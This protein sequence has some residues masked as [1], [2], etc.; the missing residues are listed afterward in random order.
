VGEASLAQGRIPSRAC[1]TQAIQPNQH[2]TA[3]YVAS[4][5]FAFPDPS[6]IPK[7][8]QDFQINTIAT[9][10]AR[11][12]NAAAIQFMF[13]SRIN[14]NDNLVEGTWMLPTAGLGTVLSHQ[15]ASETVLVSP[16][17]EAHVVFHDLLLA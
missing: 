16:V 15:E 7:G 12:R 6:T 3:L 14:T 4:V 9:N 13:T 5:F 17:H 2:R 8:Y 10:A 1:S 11:I